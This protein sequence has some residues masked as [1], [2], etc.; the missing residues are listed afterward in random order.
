MPGG[1]YVPQSSLGYWYRLR[2]LSFY[3][4]V[5]TSGCAM[6]AYLLSLSPQPQ[7]ERSV[8]ASRLS[9]LVPKP[10]INTA[11]VVSR[12]G[13]YTSDTGGKCQ[14]C[15]RPIQPYYVG[16]CVVQ[17]G[18]VITA[19]QKEPSQS[20]SCLACIASRSLEK[21]ANSCQLVSLQRQTLVTYCDEPLIYRS[22]ILKAASSVAGGGWQVTAADFK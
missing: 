15:L 6:T 1:Y 10:D 21:G 9:M 16:R 22:G 7:L 14:C 18:G 3:F 12:R 19:D 8:A 13:L 11:S 17:R 5:F 2:V 4:V 20:V